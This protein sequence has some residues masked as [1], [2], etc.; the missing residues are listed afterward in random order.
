MAIK[1]LTEAQVREMTVEEK[2]RWWLENVFQGNVPQFTFRAVT[3]GFLL[4]GVLSITNLYIGAKTGWALGVGITSVILAFLIFKVLSALRLAGNYHV[5]ENNIMQSIACSAG[6]T[7]GPLIASMAAYMVIENKVVP[8]WQMILWCFG[9]AVLGVLFAFPLKRRFINEEQLP[10]PEGQAAG[11]VLDTLHNEDEE[12]GSDA[13]LPAKLLVLFAIV[14]AGLKLLQSQA[15]MDR[16]RLGFLAVP[17]MLDNWY[18]RMAESFGWGVPS[19]L[20]T[21]LRELTVRPQ[22]DIAMIGAGGL[23]GIRTGVSL[24]LGAILN[25][26]VIVPFIIQRGDIAG[27]AGPDGTMTYGFRTITTWAL[28]CGV[29]MMTTASLLAFFAKPSVLIKPF[30][31]LFGGGS[32]RDADCLGHIELPLSY[33]LVGIPIVGAGIVYM[34][35]AFYDV[36]YW[37][38]AI[39]IPMVFVFTLIAVNSTALTSIT[40]TG[41]MGKIT[42]L[43][44]GVVAPGQIRTNIVTAC[45]SAEVAGSAS[46]L[47]QNI[48]PGYMLGAKPRLQAMG[49][50]IGAA[51]GSLCSVA[52]F[53]KLYIHGAPADLINETNPFPA[54]T[55]WKAVAE[56]LT[57]GL[58]ELAVSAQ[59]A[60]LAGGIAGIVLEIVRLASKG[61]FPISPV[62]IGLAFIIPFNTCLAMFMGSFAFWLLARL[63]PKPEDPINARYVQNQESICAGII[64]GAALMGVAVMA[65]E[66]F[67]LSGG[68]GGGH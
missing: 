30:K 1:Q 10:F 34:A 31:N 13:T 57:K 19:I 44:Y 2:D 14:A 25:Y 53:Y 61:R 5:L 51:A 39:A 63:F 52:V 62:G 18:Y 60:A 28:W 64:A 38:A 27:V 24:L 9:L 42:Q 15:I 23:M 35:H 33:S 65:I 29:T 32:R 56:I 6:Y 22:L 58:S 68:S 21:P 11:V 20:G 40:P 36:P 55:A 17:E 4:G 37:M 48:K 66:M 50:V 41:A 12:D 45:I 59:W 54:A 46:N 67:A 49:H 3:C 43:T 16:I 8:W 26:M 47:I 7:N